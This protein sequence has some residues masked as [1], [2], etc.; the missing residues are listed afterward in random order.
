MRLQRAIPLHFGAP[1]CQTEAPDRTH[2]LLEHRDATGLRQA[3]RGD[4]HFDE[5]R[6]GDAGGENGGR[7]GREVRRQRR[8]AQRRGL[9]DH[10]HPM[11]AVQEPVEQD[12][13]AL[14]QLATA[15]RKLLPGQL[16]DE[17]NEIIDV[18]EKE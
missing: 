9:R 13:L 18:L 8:P 6:A 14:S 12:T 5:L 10:V 15:L 4:H 3:G 11:D 1:R 2:Q 16:A 7:A 17:L